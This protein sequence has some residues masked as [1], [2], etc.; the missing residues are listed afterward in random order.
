MQPQNPQPI[1]VD[2][3]VEQFLKNAEKAIQALSKPENLQT[4]KQIGEE[5]STLENLRKEKI[6]LETSFGKFDKILIQKYTKLEKELKLLKKLI[7]FSHEFDKKIGNAE[8]LVK[9]RFA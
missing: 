4:F 9:I 5:M 3:D 8:N 7:E 6:K 1:H 2:L